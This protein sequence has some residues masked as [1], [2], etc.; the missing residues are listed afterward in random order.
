M[1][2]YLPK[3]QKNSNSLEYDCRIGL[4]NIDSLTELKFELSRIPPKKALDKFLDFTGKNPINQKVLFKY[5][6]NTSQLFSVI[7]QIAIFIKENGPKTNNND[8]KLCVHGL[9][10]F[11]VRVLHD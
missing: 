9:T 6:Q 4:E 5:Y 1:F 11:G 7:E 3:Y 8:F 10:E 2:N